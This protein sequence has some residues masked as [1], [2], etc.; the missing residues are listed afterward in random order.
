MKK[1][2]LCIFN[3]ISLISLILVYKLLEYILRLN[4]FAFMN[5][6]VYMFTFIVVVLS[7]SILSQIVVFLH[8]SVKKRTIELPIRIISGI[9]MAIA[10]VSG[11]ILIIYGFTT[12]IFMHQPEY[13]LEKRGKRM[14]AYVSSFLEVNVN[15]YDYVN[16]FV[17]GNKLKLSEYYGKG[18]Y[19]PFKEDEMPVIERCIYY[20]GN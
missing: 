5:V 10:A 7:L 17:R 1:K 19:D 20:D 16:P 13:V 2:K 9:G 11:S 3:C 12:F 15:Y 6:V 14:V 18:G 8:N 4:N